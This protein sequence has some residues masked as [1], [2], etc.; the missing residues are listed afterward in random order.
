M[1]AS[2]LE[3][4][5][6]Y[7]HGEG[8]K[9]SA[10]SLTSGMPQGSV[11]G[12]VLYVLY[13]KTIADIMKAHRVEYHFYAGD[14]QLYVT[15]KC[16]SMEDAYLGRTRVKCCV[17][18]INS[19]M[20]KNKLKLN[21]AK[22]ELIVISSKHQ[23]RPAIQFKWERRPSTMYPLCISLVFCWIKLYPMMIISANCASP[24]NSI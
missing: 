9:S 7:V 3:S 4:C 14:T 22:T 12:P 1:F 5:K 23:P 19:W 10:R 20:I 13:T 24:P 21:G 16:D 15:F 11:L 18:D 6:Y 17:E 2:Y 8:E